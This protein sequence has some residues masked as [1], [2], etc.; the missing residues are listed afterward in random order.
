MCSA[1]P[2]ILAGDT[3]T[4]SPDIEEPFNLGTSA[5]YTCNEGFLLEGDEVRICGGDGTAVGVWSGA[6]PVCN[7]ELF[8]TTLIY[9]TQ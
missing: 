9:N 5:T 2:P 4:Y 1:L 3:I 7:R 6:S 8:N